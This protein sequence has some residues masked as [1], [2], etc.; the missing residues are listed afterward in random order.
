MKSLCC[1]YLLIFIPQKQ[2]LRHNQPLE[3]NA[4]KLCGIKP[5]DKVLEVGFG[6]G[7]GLKAAYQ[8][9]KGGLTMI[10]C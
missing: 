2:L 4:A 9:I 10:S 3:E 7:L 6:P 8:Y 1:Y 5:D